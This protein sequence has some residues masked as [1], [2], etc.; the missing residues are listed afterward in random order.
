MYLV[1]CWCK[2]MLWG[3]AIATEVITKSLFCHALWHHHPLWF[4]NISR[5]YSFVSCFVP[6][7]QQLLI[8]VF[9]L[10]FL[11]FFPFLFLFKCSCLV[12][13]YICI[14][15]ELWPGIESFSWLFDYQGLLALCGVHDS[16]AKPILLCSCND[17]TVRMYDL[18]S[19]VS[20]PNPR[21]NSCHQFYFIT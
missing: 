7:F 16:E 5:F 3:V 12:K 18:P 1:C 20:F 2:D 19:W 13:P 10:F 6:G 11:F 21:Y 14:I 15:L 9:F 8:T 17:N 4:D